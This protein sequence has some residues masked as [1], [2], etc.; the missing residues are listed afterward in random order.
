M[1]VFNGK[2]SDIENKKFRVTDLS[3]LPPPHAQL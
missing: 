1:S 3:T 2:A